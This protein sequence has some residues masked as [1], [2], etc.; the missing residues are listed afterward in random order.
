MGRKNRGARA[1]SG[2]AAKAPLERVTRNEA[3]VFAD[4]EALC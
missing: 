4:L 2:K 1:P 3:E